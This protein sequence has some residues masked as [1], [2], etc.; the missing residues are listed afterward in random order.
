LEYQDLW[1]TSAE[2]P[3]LLALRSASS[4][5]IASRNS[6]R[7]RFVECQIGNADAAGT[8]GA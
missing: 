8:S 1:I 5:F 3:H 7:I 6:R 2:Q 4:C